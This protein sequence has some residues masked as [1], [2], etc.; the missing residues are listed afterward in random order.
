MHHRLFLPL[1]RGQV[2][3]AIGASHLHG[4]R[5]LLAM[6]RRDGYRVTRIW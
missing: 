6:L 2:F 5:G 3:V 4:D 1:R